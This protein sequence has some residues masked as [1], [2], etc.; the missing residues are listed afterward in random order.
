MCDRDKI[1]SSGRSGVGPLNL[2]KLP[3]KSIVLLAPDLLSCT[4]VD[5]DMGL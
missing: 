1:E 4:A 2:I 5:K 3:P